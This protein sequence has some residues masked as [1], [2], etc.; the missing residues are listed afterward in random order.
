MKTIEL[1]GVA[2][3]S[4]DL[5]IESTESVVGFVETIIYNWSNGDAIADVVITAEN[6]PA[7][8]AIITAADLGVADVTWYPRTLGN[9]VADAS[10]F[11]DPATKMFSVGGFKAIVS[12]STVAIGGIDG[13]ASEIVVDTSSVH[14]LSAG[15][16][17]TI[18]GTVGYDG[19][20]VVDSIT[21][22]D[23]FVIADTSH[24]IGA[25]ATGTMIRGGATY[26]FLVY[27]S[28]E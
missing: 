17:V 5:T 15:D 24:N 28:D 23:T 27:V 20:Y 7:T 19:T 3:D 16:T 22:T 12:G 1:T 11:T 9:K 10:A 14:N 26:R 2:D 13:D 4:G 25:E 21:D 18:A 8:Q 6:G